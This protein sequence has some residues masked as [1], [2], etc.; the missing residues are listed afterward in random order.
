MST[1]DT[2]DRL[3]SGV[4]GLDVVLKG[5]FFKGGLYL[6]QGTPGTGKT[7]LAHQLCFNHIANIGPRALYVTLLSEFHARMLQYLGGLSFFDESKLPDQFSYISAFRVMRDE[8]LSGLA[9]LIRREIIA[10]KVSLLIVD[11]LVAA[12]RAADND[13]AF[14]EFMHELQGI[15]IATNCTVVLVASTGRDAKHTPEHT[16]VDGILQL[17]DHSFGWST[18]RALQVVKVRGSDYLRG[19]HAYRLTQHGVVVHPRI[20]ALLEEPAIPD[21]ANTERF[22][23]GERHLDAM[24]GGGLVAG[25]STLILGPS[26][27]GKTTLG[28]QFLCGCSDAEPGLLF[29]FYETPAR[30]LAKSH[31]VCK[32][33]VG[34]LESGAVE[35][36]WQPPTK[37]SLDACGDRLLA[38]VRRRGVRRLFIDGLGALHKAAESIEREA[39]FLSAL[40]HQLRAEEVTTVSTLEVNTII[41]PNIKA[42][43][44]DLSSLAENL[45]LLRYVELRARLHRLISILKVRDSDFD[46]LMHEFV[47]ID[48]GVVIDESPQ[49]A[50]TIMRALVHDDAAS[51]PPKRQPPAVG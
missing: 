5:G 48:Q 15:A 7:T 20:E 22:T 12:Q 35:M 8:G 4:P 39:S 31:Q 13:Q 50:E 29:G 42:P 46:P 10:K 19:R 9:V 21:K 47:V 24:L 23:S 32:P 3:T 45:V 49:N 51:L 2:L 43:I 11:G 34:L 44:G 33:L 37:G 41:G 25:T 36:L 14:N 27:V 17:S 40:M 16:M 1:G 6:I 38:A 30:I 18:E 28:L 26:G